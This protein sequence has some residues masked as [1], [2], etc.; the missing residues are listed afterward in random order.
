LRKIQAKTGEWRT[1]PSAPGKTAVVEPSLAA[2]VEP[3]PESVNC[4]NRGS[5]SLVSLRRRRELRVETLSATIPAEAPQFRPAGTGVASSRCISSPATQSL[6]SSP[7]R[8]PRCLLPDAACED[9]RRDPGFLCLHFP[10]TRLLR[11]GD[12][13]RAIPAGRRRRKTGNPARD[14]RIIAAGRMSQLSTR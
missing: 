7:T 4:F 8:F 6:T 14:P 11:P 2:A 10:S 5:V 12:D 1:P 3:D 13:V 9:A